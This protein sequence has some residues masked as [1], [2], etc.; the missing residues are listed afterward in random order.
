MKKHGEYG[1]EVIQGD[2]FRFLGF[3]AA[4]GYSECYSPRL[5]SRF[6]VKLDYL[7][8]VQDDELASLFELEVP[9]EYKQPLSPAPQTATNLS[10]EI[11]F[12][13]KTKEN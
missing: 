6:W 9:D 5:K 2:F 7:L 12:R 8:P 4:E 13:Q 1:E 10:L 3:S 11:T